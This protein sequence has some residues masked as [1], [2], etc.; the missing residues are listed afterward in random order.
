MN[1]SK[2]Y[3]LI[4]DKRENTMT[5]TLV[6]LIADKRKTKARMIRIWDEPDV[7]N[8]WLWIYD[9]KKCFNL[10][11]KILKLYKL[12]MSIFKEL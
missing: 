11:L 1:L 3:L 12:Q 2:N 6:N 10:E 8:G 5:I 7:E 9:I 4:Q